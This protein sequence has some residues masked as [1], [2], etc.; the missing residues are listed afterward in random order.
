M[1]R[2]M[3]QGREREGVEGFVRLALRPLGY[4]VARAEGGGGAP[5]KRNV[6]SRPVRRSRVVFSPCVP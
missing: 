1:D 3:K 4:D 5:R 2:R 6:R